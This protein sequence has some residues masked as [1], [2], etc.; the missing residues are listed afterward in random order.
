MEFDPFLFFSF[1]VPQPMLK[2]EA[3]VRSYEAFENTGLFCWALLQK[4]PIMS[5]SLL[6]VA[7][8]HLAFLRIYRLLLGQIKFLVPQLTL[9]TKAQVRS[10]EAFLR[11]FGI[12]AA[13]GRGCWLIGA[14]FA[15]VV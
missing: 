13:D 14:V 12:W 2:P 7:T 6:I 15:A 4:K 5:T 1:L 9:K 10:Y 11:S 8:P 3:Q